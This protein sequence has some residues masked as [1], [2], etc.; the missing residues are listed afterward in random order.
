MNSLLECTSR[1]K[2]LSRLQTLIKWPRSLKDICGTY[3]TCTCILSMCDPQKIPLNFLFIYLFHSFP[4]FTFTLCM[5]LAF[6]YIFV[7]PFRKKILFNQNIDY[8]TTTIKR[9]QD[10]CSCYQERSQQ[11]KISAVIIKLLTYHRSDFNLNKIDVWRSL[12]FL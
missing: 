6:I 4:N 10:F 3:S 8:V 1:W 2:M 11:G 5:V 12:N 9:V 7:V